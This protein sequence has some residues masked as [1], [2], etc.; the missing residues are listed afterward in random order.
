MLS[1]FG[2]SFGASVLLALLAPSLARGFAPT[3]LLRPQTLLRR[4]SSFAAKQPAMSAGVS[5]SDVS[6]AVLAPWRLDAD[7]P[8]A[9]H[10]KVKDIFQYLEQHPVIVGGEPME[11][12][13]LHVLSKRTKRRFAES[14][15]F[16]LL[17]EHLPGGKSDADRLKML[18]ST[19]FT[20]GDEAAAMCG[21]L[22]LACGGLDEAHDR[23]TPMS[24][25]D[26]TLFGG[27]PIAGSSAREDA[28]LLHC[29]VHIR[30]GKVASLLLVPAFFTASSF[31]NVLE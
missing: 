6:G 3:L 10:Q 21:L 28:T 29:L 23:I 4:S 5:E 30:E 16:H 19:G 9:Q 15:A 8:A 1:P 24:W 7:H 11:Y 17:P 25:P 26:G 14:P 20:Q 2:A 18:E 27:P 31:A 22:Q 13:P 12:E